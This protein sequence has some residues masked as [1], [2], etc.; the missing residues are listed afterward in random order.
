MKKDAI[1]DVAQDT[2][3]PPDFIVPKNRIL[4]GIRGGGKSIVNS[5][6][7]VSESNFSAIQAGS[8]NSSTTTTT[9]TTHVDLDGSALPAFTIRR[10]IFILIL[11]QVEISFTN[12]LSS[13]QG[14]GP[15]VYTHI[16]GDVNDS[17]EV[18][19]GLHGDTYKNGGLITLSNHNTRLITANNPPTSYTIKLQWVVRN[20]N[21][22]ATARNRQ[23]SRIILGE[24]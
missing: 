5:T 18:R 22:I 17:Q 20:V 1:K 24:S 8:V 14:I 10:S 2:I 4:K 6:G 16:S 21:D 12:T 19:M 15:D 3:V 11:S 13:G 7:L 23:I 9:S